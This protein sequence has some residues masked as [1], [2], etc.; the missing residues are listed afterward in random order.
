MLA[1]RAEGVVMISDYKICDLRMDL[2][3]T[4]YPSTEQIL[5]GQHLFYQAQAVGIVF[6]SESRD[7]GH[8]QTLSGVC[9]T[10]ENRH[11]PRHRFGIRFSE[12]PSPLQAIPAH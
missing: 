4:E 7:Q 11:F 1:E 8:H 10:L 6:N 12:R 3:A 9:D 5:E 2:G